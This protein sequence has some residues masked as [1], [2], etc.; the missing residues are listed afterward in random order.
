MKAYHKLAVAA[1]MSAGMLA[2]AGGSASAAIVCNAYGSCWHVRRAYAYPPEAHIVVH[3]NSWR[4]RAR[5][6]FV[7]RDH[8]GRGYWRN[9]V[10]VT[11]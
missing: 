4:W 5:A 3:P 2:F 1:V 6:H 9:G 8:P 10:W 7:W 11:F